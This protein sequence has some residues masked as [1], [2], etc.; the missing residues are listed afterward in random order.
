MRLLLVGISLCNGWFARFESNK[1]YF[2]IKYTKLNQGHKGQEKA[3]YLNDTFKMNF[4]KEELILH[5]LLP[6]VNLNYLHQNG[7]ILVSRMI[8]AEH[9]FHIDITNAQNPSDQETVKK[10]SRNFPV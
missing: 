8:R 3:K 7:H 10:S 4:Y 9:G 1:Y 6:S 2:A 5:I